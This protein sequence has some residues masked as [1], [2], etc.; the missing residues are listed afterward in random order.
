MRHSSWGA[1]L[2]HESRTI[3]QR[4]TELSPHAGNAL[5]P[6]ATLSQGRPRQQ[7]TSSSADQTQAIISQHL[8]PNLLRTLLTDTGNN[9][10][11]HTKT[12][13]VCG[14]VMLLFKEQPRAECP[15]RSPQPP[16]DSGSLS[17]RAPVCVR[18]DGAPGSCTDATLSCQVCSDPQR[19]RM[20]PK[21]SPARACNFV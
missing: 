19:R 10:I 14:E 20:V 8:S 3:L 12:T 21:T 9:A 5:T 4:C 13:S 11:A 1:H 16:P 17:R 18:R 2:P 7:E 15:L 6:K